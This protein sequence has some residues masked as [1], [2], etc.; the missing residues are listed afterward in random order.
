M[1]L[2]NEKVI[3]LIK[4]ADSVVLEEN[5]ETYPDDEREDGETDLAFALGEVEYLIEDCF[6]DDGHIFYDDLRNARRLLRET[7]D[8][9]IIPISIETFRPLHGYNVWDIE[10]ARAIVNEYKRLKKL[11]STL[12]RMYYKEK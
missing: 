9:K 2:T 5:I 4:K 1:K 11:Q 8:G 3:A 7:D 10:D 6:N 12:R